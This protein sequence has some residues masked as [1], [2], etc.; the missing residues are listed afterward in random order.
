VV[1]KASANV[2]GVEL[3]LLEKG[4][5]VV[6]NEPVLD[7]VVIAADGLHEPPIAQDPQLMRNGRLG[8]PNREGEIADTKRSPRKCIED[9]CP[10]RI[11]QCRE[12]ADHK[13]Q[14][15]LFRQSRVGIGYGWSIDWLRKG[16]HLPKDT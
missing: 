13:L 2:I 7:L 12:R 10:R 1:W 14:D 6:T 16:G 4:G 11:T 5:D 3:R 9:L 15:F 8:H